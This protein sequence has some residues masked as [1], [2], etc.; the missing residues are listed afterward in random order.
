MC[1]CTGHCQ[2]LRA[3]VMHVICEQQRAATHTWVFELVWPCRQCLF[4]LQ[5]IAYS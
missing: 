3:L 4:V 2:Q 1:Y 5:G